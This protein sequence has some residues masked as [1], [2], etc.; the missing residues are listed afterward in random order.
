MQG[1]HETKRYEYESVGGGGVAKNVGMGGGA[2]ILY[3]L[4]PHIGNIEFYFYFFLQLKLTHNPIL[5]TK[6]I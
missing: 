3:T 5:N 4:L 1:G 2:H 6:K